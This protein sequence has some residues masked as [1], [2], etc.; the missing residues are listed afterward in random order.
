MKVINVHQ[1]TIDWNQQRKHNG[2]L[3][4]DRQRVLGGFFRKGFERGRSGVRNY[5]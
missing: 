2:K 1:R 5:G 4:D 3:K